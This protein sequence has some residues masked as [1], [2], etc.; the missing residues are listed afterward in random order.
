MTKTAKAAHAAPK[1]AKVEEAESAVDAAEVA[2][3][4]AKETLARI[5]SP[6]FEKDEQATQETIAH[7]REVQE[8]RNRQNLDTRLERSG[9]VY[10]DDP[11]TNQSYVAKRPNGLTSIHGS[12]AKQLVISPLASRHPERGLT[13]FLDADTAFSVGENVKIWFDVVIPDGGG[14]LIDVTKGQPA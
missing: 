1:T 13:V 3:D 8:L 6:H 10:I 14:P 4:R 11:A 7:D 2:V 12:P 5:N 9:Y